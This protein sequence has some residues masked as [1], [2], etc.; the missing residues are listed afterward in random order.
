MDTSDFTSDP[1]R[2]ENMERILD[3]AERLFKHYGYAKTTVA[4]IARDLGMSPA[5]VY[6]FYASKA[7]IHKALANRMLEASRDV[8]RL[9]AVR[10]VSATERL[11]AHFIDQHRIT[12]ETLLHDNKVH[13]MVVIAIEEQWSVIEDHIAQMRAIIAGLIREGIAAGEFREQDAELAAENLGACMVTLC[14]PQIIAECLD[15]SRRSTPAILVDF[16]L[17]ALK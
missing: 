10:P 5:N 16:A 13:E 12:V 4:D 17:R 3:T 8:A 1:V 7:E 6:R 11:Q 15:E 14:H 2:R 9:N